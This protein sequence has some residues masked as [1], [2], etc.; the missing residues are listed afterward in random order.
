[1]YLYFFPLHGQ[2]HTGQYFFV[3]VFPKKPPSGSFV[4]S[5]YF[6]GPVLVWPPPKYYLYTG[7]ILTWSL[8]FRR[9]KVLFLNDDL[10]FLPS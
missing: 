8:A 3:K 5:S 1:M 10:L 6:R 4:S 2:R 7:P 9:R